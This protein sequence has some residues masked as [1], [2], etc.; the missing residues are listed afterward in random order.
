ME[1]HISIQAVRV[2]CG[3]P[4]TAVGDPTVIDRDLRAACDWQPAGERPC[5][6]TI[7]ARDLRDGQSNAR[8]PT[9]PTCALFVDL[10]LQESGRTC[11]ENVE[12]T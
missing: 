1:T 5:L 12:A 10:A 2:L 7:H 6:F 8:L 11:G 3:L 4:A 9:C